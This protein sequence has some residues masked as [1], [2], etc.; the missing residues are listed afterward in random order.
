MHPDDST[1]PPPPLRIGLP[2]RLGEM[3]IRQGLVSSEE[4]QAALAEQAAGSEWRLGR[5]LV[6]RGA[7]DDRTLVQA[8]AHQFHVPVV[9]LRIDPPTSGALARLAPDAARRLHALP[10]RLDADA[11]V[12]AVSDPPVRELRVA[13]ERSTGFPVRLVLVAADELADA[14]DRCYDDEVDLTDRA[15][16][17]DPPAPTERRPASGPEPEAVT[18]A[19]PDAHPESW[20]AVG[21][22]P[23]DPAA[24]APEGVP[25]VAPPEPAGAADAARP[26]DDATDLQILVW[27]LTE[28]VRRDATAVHLDHSS[29]GL[30]IRYR[31]DGS[32]VPGPSL[33]ETSGTMVC[34]RL[35]KAA[36]LDPAG[37]GLHEGAFDT[38]V[39]GRSIT[40]HVIATTTASGTHVVVRTGE[41]VQP[42]RLEDLRIGPSDAVSVRAILHEGRGAVVVAAPLPA[43]AAA[44][45]RVLVDETGPDGHVVVTALRRGAPVVDGAVRLGPDAGADDVVRFARAFGADLFV[46]DADDAAT[47]RAAVEVA[48][49][50]LVI[51]AVL[52]QDP[53][54]VVAELVAD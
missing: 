24:P 12:V 46:T 35:L 1:V 33:P 54:D 37:D 10:L 30:R 38:V 6:R 49:D 31:V 2:S 41:A 4:V 23:G 15:A 9:D 44:V 53:S 13:V 39:D 48:G 19:P 51:L 34:H 32:L 45:V 26:I 36:A 17:V 5:L 29:A 50:R 40:C 52:G 16:S 7:L 25:P 20:P 42:G 22:R 43:V 18:T 47:R 28:A 11:L 21:P 3:L 14:I 8:I 27:L